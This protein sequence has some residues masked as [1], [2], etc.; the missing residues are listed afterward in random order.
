MPARDRLARREQH[1][2]VG[3]DEHPRRRRGVAGGGERQQRGDG[4]QRPHLTSCGRATRAGVGDDARRV[5]AE[6]L[7]EQ[8]R[9]DAAEVGRRAQVAVLVEHVE[10][11]ELADHPAGGARADQQPEPG[12]AV[13]GALGVLLRAAPEL[14]PHV[15]EHAVGEPARLEV[16]LER[17][18][19]CR[20]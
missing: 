10:P 18:E 4:E 14:R 20:R 9:V 6:P 1:P 7:L 5:G 17:G 11:R 15:H 2:L 19:R 8:P 12:G 13:V 16:A 3:G